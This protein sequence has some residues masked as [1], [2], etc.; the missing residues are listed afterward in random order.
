VANIKPK[1]EFEPIELKV[2]SGWYVRVT[3]PRGRQP[4]LGNFNTEVEARKWIKRRS[5]AWLK[6]YQRSRHV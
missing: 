2:G 3:L 4:Q 5:S 1:L 6:K